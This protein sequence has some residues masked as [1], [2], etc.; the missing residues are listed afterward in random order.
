M[1][2]AANPQPEE[3]EG[4]KVRHGGHTNVSRNHTLILCLTFSAR[5]LLVFRKKNHFREERIFSSMAVKALLSHPMRPPPPWNYYRG[6]LVST[7]KL[8]FPKFHHRT[9]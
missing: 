7:C 6:V 1:K 4:K 8:A 9:K 5:R 3:E 2:A